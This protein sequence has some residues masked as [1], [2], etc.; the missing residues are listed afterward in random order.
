MYNPGS[1][2]GADQRF[3]INKKGVVK[4]KKVLSKMDK[5]YSSKYKTEKRSYKSFD[6][7]MLNRRS[8]K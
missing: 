5:E 2:F 3:K 4:R 1:I 6:N 7:N 8:A